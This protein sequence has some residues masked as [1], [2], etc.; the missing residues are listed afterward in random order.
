MFLPT[1]MVIYYAHRHIL[2]NIKSYCKYLEI[3]SAVTGI[4]NHRLGIDGAH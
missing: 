3:L 4:C 2:A 1:R